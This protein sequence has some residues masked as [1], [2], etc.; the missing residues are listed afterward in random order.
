MEFG[1]Y[2]A[3]TS[4]FCQSHW[5][6]RPWPN[7]VAVVLIWAKVYDRFVLASMKISEP[8]YQRISE[9]SDR[10]ALTLIL[11]ERKIIA[12]EEEVPESDVR[13]V[14]KRVIGFNWHDCLL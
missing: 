10:N 7:S 12:G 2:N 13:N 11:W 8:K 6:E 9:N 3:R 1:V 5:P 14:D 4:F